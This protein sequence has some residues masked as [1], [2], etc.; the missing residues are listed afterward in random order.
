MEQGGSQG[1]AVPDARRTCLAHSGS[2]MTRKEEMGP[3]GASACTQAALVGA[4]RGTL[5]EATSLTK[6]GWEAQSPCSVRSQCCW[7]APTKDSRRLACRAAGHPNSPLHPPPTQPPTRGQQVH[8][9]RLHH[10]LEQRLEQSASQQVLDVLGLGVGHRH[11]LQ[12]RS[13]GGAGGRWVCLAAHPRAACQPL[14]DKHAVADGVMATGT[15]QEPQQARPPLSA[16]AGLP[17][18]GQPRAPTC[19][20]TAG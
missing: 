18:G 4:P 3:A 15:G 7:S 2:E 5:P 6:N 11:V 17:G 16:G 9:P 19:R 20:P 10:P 12:R 14:P 8:G 1:G 13:W